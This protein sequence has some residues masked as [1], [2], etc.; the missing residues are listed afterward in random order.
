[1]ENDGTFTADFEYVAGSGDLDECHGRFGV[2]PEHPE[3]IY[4]YY[5][6][7]E[8]PFIGRS[9]RGEPDES[10]FKHPGPGAPFPGF[11][12]PGGRRPPPR[13]R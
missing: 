1:M 4:H 9:W 6:T 7:D 13:R 11:G 10:F 3:G 2:T 8:F 5:V 12:P